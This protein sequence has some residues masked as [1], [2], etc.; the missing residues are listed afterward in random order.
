M[1]HT[2]HNT[3]YSFPPYFTSADIRQ[4][5]DDLKGIIGNPHK[6]SPEKK[7]KLTKPG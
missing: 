4:I 7:A 5:A 1:I 6:A 2:G 3:E